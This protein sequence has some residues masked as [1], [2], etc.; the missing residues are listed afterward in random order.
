MPPLPAPAYE[1]NRR[2][3]ELGLDAIPATTGEVLGA[4]AEDAW[5]RNPLPSL[6]RMIQRGAAER[7]EG[8]DVGLGPRGFGA[9]ATGT[10]DDL[11]TPEEADERYGIKGHLGFE[12]PTPERVAKDLYDLKREELRRRNI[13]RRAEGGV[14]QTAAQFG[15][16]LGVSA[17]DPLNVASAFLPVVGQARYAAWLARAG[18]GA[19]ARAAVRLRAGA[20][21]GAAGAALVEPIVY[22]GARQ[23]QADYTALDSLLNLAFG[24]VLGG[25]LHAGLGAIGDAIAR[26]RIQEPVLREAIASIIEDRPV[27]V[28]APIKAELL[29]TSQ[30]LEDLST[31]FDRIVPVEVRAP[32]SIGLRA[33]D[34]T[35]ARFEAERPF[36]RG[37]IVQRQAD[38]AAAQ[39]EVHAIAERM[40]GREDISR[41]VSEAETGRLQQALEAAEAERK[42]VRAEM[43]PVRDAL[44]RAQAEAERAE[45]RAA[46]LRGLEADT[47]K[48]ARAEAQAERAKAAA[49]RE[50]ARLDDMRLRETDAKTRA[51]AIKEQL[52]RFKANLEAPAA[53]LQAPL[54]RA[55]E[56]LAAAEARLAA[57]ET[58]LRDRAAA[59]R[60]EAEADIRRQTQEFAEGE[61]MTVEERRVATTIERIVSRLPEAT[62]EAEIKAIEADVADL[63]TALRQEGILT[64]GQSDALKSADVI[65]LA[66]ARARAADAAANCQILRSADE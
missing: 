38:V 20:I 66:E 27:R 7:G 64:E 24:T 63:E 60:A 4:T 47:R 9:F 46:P 22:I 55:R 37:E 52:V 43:A 41:Q 50:Q 31:V 11:L 62:P 30:G 42:A 3:Q 10:P 25:G 32:E 18:E 12:E 40:S 13:F 44:K 6:W 17:L 1:P 59:A 35:R 5:A 19:G 2:L 48:V 16:G 45:A 65:D 58:V 57:S 53:E 8:Q 15:V 28:D 54:A 61:R 34:E 14:G 51:D 56:R 21:E 33:A 26:G 29:R 49:A 23:E 39:A 36:L